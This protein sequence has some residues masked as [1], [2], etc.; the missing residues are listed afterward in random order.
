MPR[1]FPSS[2]W[3]TRLLASAKFNPGTAED[4]ARWVAGKL[5]EAVRLASRSGSVLLVSFIF[6]TRSGIYELRA[7]LMPSLKRAFCASNFD[8]KFDPKNI[9]YIYYQLYETSE[10]AATEEVKAYEEGWSPSTWAQLS[11][12]SLAERLMRRIRDGDVNM[13]ARN[14]LVTSGAGSVVAMG[15]TESRPSNSGLTDEVDCLMLLLDGSPT[16]SIDNLGSVREHVERYGYAIL[17]GAARV[18]VLAVGGRGCQYFILAYGRAG[19][20]TR[21]A[22]RWEEVEDYVLSLGSG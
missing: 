16:L 6:E 10:S 7:W 17:N 22:D 12:A 4:A 21:C 20:D 5:S 3:F 1:A 9:L 14:S 19:V 15:T 13:V 2:P 8:E 18:C 11:G